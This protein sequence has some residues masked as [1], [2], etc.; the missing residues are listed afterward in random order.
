MIKL[1]YQ[2]QAAKITSSFDV[3]SL[4]LCKYAIFISFPHYYNNTYLL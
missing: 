3:T 4:Q 1:K 2:V